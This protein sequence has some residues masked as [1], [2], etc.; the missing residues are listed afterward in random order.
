MT[1]TNQGK[2]LKSNKKKDVLKVPY[3]NK[4][5]DLMHNANFY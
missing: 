5:E 4:D 3:H 2:N 1:P